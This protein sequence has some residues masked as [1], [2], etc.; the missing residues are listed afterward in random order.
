VEDART[1]APLAVHGGN[2]AP[3]YGVD[4]LDKFLFDFTE[5]VNYHHHPS[6][7]ATTV[8]HIGSI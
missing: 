8:K 2:I 4:A 7:C 3:D 6:F 5:I 1:G